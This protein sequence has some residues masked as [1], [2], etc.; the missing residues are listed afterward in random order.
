M[1]E[2]AV[3]VGESVKSGVRAVANRF[4]CRA[5]HIWSEFLIRSRI[6]S[7]VRDRI[8]RRVRD[9]IGWRVEE[10]LRE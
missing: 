9:Q 2:R 6:E 3:D 4:A 1:Y 8:G 7:P 10:I 5:I